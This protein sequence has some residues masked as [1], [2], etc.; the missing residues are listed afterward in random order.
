MLEIKQFSCEDREAGCI[1]DNATPSFRYHAASDRPGTVVMRATVSV[2]DWSAEIS[3]QKSTVY[4]GP[5]LAPRRQYEAKLRIEGNRGEKA[6]QTLRFE[7]GKLDEGW[8][9]K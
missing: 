3:S 1:T 8:Q 9:G 6:E 5:P 2:G 4:A 7:T